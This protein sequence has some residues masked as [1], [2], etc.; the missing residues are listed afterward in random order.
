[1]R[2]NTEKHMRKSMGKNLNYL[3]DEVMRQ[4]IPLRSFFSPH[5]NATAEEVVKKY[6]CFKLREC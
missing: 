1:M 2:K 5:K 4:G 3:D 6:R